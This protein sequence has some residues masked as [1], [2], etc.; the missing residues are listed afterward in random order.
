MWILIG[1]RWRAGFLD[2]WKAPGER[3][4]D[5]RQ[6]VVVCELEDLYLRQ[7]YDVRRV[8]DYAREVGPVEVARKV[9]SRLSETWRND[10]VAACG[11]GVDVDT[12]EVFRFFAPCVPR[13]VERVVIP[14]VLCW[15]V[16]EAPLGMSCGEGLD[17]RFRPWAGWTRESGA[18]LD[19]LD[20]LEALV[21]EYVDIAGQAVELRPPSVVAERRGETVEGRRIHASVF[22]YGHYVRS[23]VLPSIPP[24]IEVVT[25]HELDPVLAPDSFPCVDTCPM[26]RDDERA[27]V[28]FVGGFHASHATIATEALRR[29]AAVICEK[30]LATT[31]DQLTDL[32][33]VFDD[34]SRYFASFQRRFLAPNEWVMEDLG[35]SKTD[36]MSYHALVHEV[37]LP[38]GH[39]YHWPAAGTRMLS[40]GCHWVDHFLWLNDFAAVER[41]DARRGPNG[42]LMCEL[43]LEN[44]AFFTLTL[45]DRGSDRLG[46]REHTELRVRDRTAVIEDMSSYRCE[47][48]RGVIRRERFPRL[49][50]HRAMY[51]EFA[52]RIIGGEAG[53]RREHVERSAGVV[54]QLEA[55]LTS[56]SSSR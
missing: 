25:V 43:V 13:G 33:R 23:V 15:A 31:T 39:W 36:P 51:A 9:L 19:D 22:G 41:A 26:L 14:D 16:D 50:A 48:P 45:T 17:P 1:D 2:P 8:I 53:E 5:V 20:E 42:E 21:A 44:G 35:W 10:K 56:A 29:G 18:A 38:E 7:P 3:R 6:W 30:P 47:G 40:N 28:V 52:R 12:G 49:L 34:S 32:L 46:V 24:E 55:E 4:L 11:V 27:D 37:S 54:L